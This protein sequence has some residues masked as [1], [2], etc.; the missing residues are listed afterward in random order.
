MIIYTCMPYRVSAFT[1]YGFYYRVLLHDN[2]I[3][4]LLHDYNMALYSIV[5]R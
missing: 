3:K 1:N 5:T 2:R 4:T